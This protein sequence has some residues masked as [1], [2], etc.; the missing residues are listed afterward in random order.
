MVH[1]YTVTV[2]Y[3]ADL[4]DVTIPDTDVCTTEEGTVPGGLNNVATVDWNGNEGSDDECV[5]PGK[6]TLDK[7][8]VSARPAGDGTWEVVY[9]LTVGNVGGEATTYDLD[10]ELLFAPVITV[11]SVAVTGPDGVTLNDGFDGD[12]DRRIA[13]DVVIGGLDDE[14]YAPHVYRVT[15]VASVPL[16]FTDV[17][18]D[19]TGSPACT[20]AP[21]EPHRA[22]AE[23][24][25]DAHGRDRRDA[26]RH[27]LRPVPSIDIT[28]TMDGTPVAGADGSWT[29]AYTVTATNDGA[30]AGVYDLT[31]RLRYGAGIEVRTAKVTAAPDGVTPS[32]SW[33]GQG[34]E[35]DPANVVATGVSLAAGAVHTYRVEV[36]A[37]L[38]T[39]QADDT[40]FTCPEPGS[41]GSGG[42]ANTAGIGHNGLTDA[43]QACATPDRPGDP[44]TPG[45][46]GSP[47]AT[48]G[49]TLAWVAGGRRS[50]C[51]S[52]SWP[53]PRP[54]VGTP[55][56]DGATRK[57]LPTT[58]PTGR[59][60]LFVGR[61]SALRAGG[62]PTAQHACRCHEREAG[63]EERPGR[64]D[65]ERG[66]DAGDGEDGGG[67]GE[68]RV[69]HGCCPSGTGEGMPRTSRSRARRGGSAG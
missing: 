21:G 60:G 14:G 5:R 51:S 26:D 41:D 44:G 48:T 22:G 62:G 10:D 4:T 16:H 50:C 31:D 53:W 42:F 63:D 64:D 9:D 12:A 6:P 19:G 7:A 2:R 38:D 36:V 24:R 37:T 39:E 8:L 67:L 35:G 1:T 49:A 45:K 13:T 61:L 58:V 54:G 59:A 55:S 30:A 57:A 52:A 27:R 34:A 11:G 3:A 17:E 15:V 68:G 56:T 32:G 18:D 33:T 66:R 29:V 40:T 23:Q 69:V 28:K 20:A 65:V 46:P 25:G 47:L 43:A